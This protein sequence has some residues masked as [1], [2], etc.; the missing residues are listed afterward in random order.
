MSEPPLNVHD[1][2]GLRNRTHVFR[3]RSEA[4]AAI[5]TLLRPYRASDA[6]IF[7]IPAGGI[8]VAA[9]AARQLSLPLDFLAVSKITLPWNTEAG[10]GA[11]A[12]DGTWQLNEG[13]VQQAGL[14]LNTVQAGIK[15]TQDKVKRR[16]Q[17]FRELLPACHVDN[18]TA[19]IVDD[20]LASGFTMRVAVKALR[21][22]RAASIV[23]AV[24]TGHLSA[25]AEL[26]HQV[27]EVYCA[28]MRDGLHFAVANA[29]AYWSDVS[30]D[31]VKATLSAFQNQAPGKPASSE[32]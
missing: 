11:V 3:D 26:A 24:P 13:L 6:I 16:A 14:D 17:E 5:A 30:E 23:V 10:Y 22:Q 1:Q 28:N 29:Y 2:K 4:G 18:S 9:T 15:A 7:G 8:P 31:E 27:D 25:L 19:I 12:S 21:N 32:K 20:G